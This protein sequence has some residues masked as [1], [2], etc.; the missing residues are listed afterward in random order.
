MLSEREDSLLLVVDI[1]ESFREVLPAFDQVVKRSAFLIECANVLGVPIMVTEQNPSRLGATASELIDILGDSLYFEKM[2]FSALGNEEVIH[3]LVKS[4]RRNII[5]A[6]IESHICICQSAY[7]LI[8]EE[9]EVNLVV[10]AIGSRT[11]LAHKIALKRLR[12]IGVTLTHSESVVYEWLGAA[13]DPDFRSIL[14]IVKK[15]A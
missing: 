5:L 7:H 9:F 15:Y 4:K 14:P 11:E 3:H 10:D 8:A 13:S 6:G 12:D 2:S 1:Q